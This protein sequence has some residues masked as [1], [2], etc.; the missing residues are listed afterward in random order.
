[1]WDEGALASLDDAGVSARLE[2]LTREEGH[3][4]RK[5]GQ[6]A[7]AV[8]DRT[9]EAVY[10]VPYLAHATMEPMNCTADVRRDGV[11]LWVPT[12]FQTG[13]R[14]YGGGS[15]G[16]AAGIAGVA[17]EA[18]E[19]HTTHLGGGF[20]RRAETDFVAEACQVSKA[21]GA[22]V[23][24]VWSREDDIRHDQYRPAARHVL[25]GGLGADGAPLLWSH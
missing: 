18:V 13:P 7:A 5:V 25:K 14:L 23:K 24:L 15:R 3:L 20:G 22:P 8:C 19:V 11:T 21:V 16:V 9:L 10:E 2:Q 17:P 6:G 1:E 4:A 12:Q